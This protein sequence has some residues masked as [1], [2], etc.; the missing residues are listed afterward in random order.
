MTN[1]L[2]ATSLALVLS[3]SIAGC[4]SSSGSAS[5]PTGGRSG[6]LT[7][8]AAFYP[9][10]WMAEQVGGD[11]VRV[12][13]LTAP[14]A[15]PHDLELTPKQV[16]QI[17]EADVVVKLGGFQPAVDDAAGDADNVFDVADVV[18]LDL[19]TTAEHDHEHGEDEADAHDE[20]GAG[21]DEEGVTD[22]HFWLDPTLLAEVAPAL[23]DRFA[24]LDPDHAEG[25]RQRADA[26]VDVLDGID[27]D[28]ATGLASCT[29]TD[30][31]TSHQAF[32]YLARRYGL[33]Q[34]GINGLSPEQE[35]S[36]ARLAEV[37]DFVEDHDVKTIYFETLVPSDIARTVADETGAGTAV[38]DPIEGV[39]DASAGTDY[40][41]IMASNLQ[42][43]RKGQPCT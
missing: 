36:P 16:A 17:S 12:T 9:L 5:A 29:S 8:D 30:I 38:L 23:A 15:E 21:H 26:T 34:V 42:A 35:P 18:D 32:G 40:P 43:L 1:R 22:P 33:T 10:Q 19:T 6:A 27:H 25:Y 41:S 39:T 7:V 3:A 13:S 37:A 20:E 28:F 14:G 31:V 2:L 4:G 24:E 11:Q